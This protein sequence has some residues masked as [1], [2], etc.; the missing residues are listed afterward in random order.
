MKT[1]LLISLLFLPV[2]FI[3]AA[4]SEAPVARPALSRQ[5]PPAKVLVDGAVNP[6]LISDYRAYSLF[7][8]FIS[9]RVGRERNAIRAYIRQ[10]FRDGSCPDS[11]EDLTEVEK[12]IDNL[13]AAGEEFSTSAQPLDVRIK[14]LAEQLLSD[15]PDTEQDRIRREKELICGAAIASLTN[16][17]G[18]ASAAKVRLHIEGMKRKMTIMH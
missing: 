12:Q 7:F 8:R 2:P 14:E 4:R 17:L 11:S 9:N 15:G 16:R 5:T 13:I 1:L 6:E 3:V 10:I 18:F